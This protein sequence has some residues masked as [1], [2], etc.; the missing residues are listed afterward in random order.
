LSRARR[1]STH[2]RLATLK[3]NL[4]AARCL[5]PPASPDHVVPRLP[6]PGAGVVLVRPD[7]VAGHAIGRNVLGVSRR[8]AAAAAAGQAQARRKRP[9]SGSLAGRRWAGGNPG[10]TRE[11]PPLL[12]DL[13]CVG[14]RIWSV[15]L[16][17]PGTADHPAMR[18]SRTEI[19]NR[20]IRPYQRLRARAWSLR[21]R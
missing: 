10:G 18:G 17:T 12:A 6:R 11:P 3:T 19:S 14:A 21:R 8:A 4:L 7:R 5:R 13:N 16:R 9:G 20:S 1:G 2:G 15:A